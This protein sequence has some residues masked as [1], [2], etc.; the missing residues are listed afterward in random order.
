M[1]V[2][3][4][5]NV[6]NKFFIFCETNGR[7]IKDYYLVVVFLYYR[8]PSD[9]SQDIGKSVNPSYWK[10]LL[11]TKRNFQIPEFFDHQAIFRRFCYNQCSSIPWGIMSGFL[12]ILSALASRNRTPFWSDGDNVELIVI[13]LLIWLARVLSRRLELF[14]RTTKIIADNISKRAPKIPN[15]VPRNGLIWRNVGARAGEKSEK[16]KTTESGGKKGN[17]INI[18]KKAGHHHNYALRTSLFLRVLQRVSLERHGPGL[19]FLVQRHHQHI[20]VHPGLESL[21]LEER[22]SADWN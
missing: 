15:R 12:S 7:S 10:M 21:K 4:I 8:H 20:I 16:G 5:R 14:K 13:V 3:L 11:Q 22:C 18:T 1:F 2:D 6:R 9:N 17:E 19:A